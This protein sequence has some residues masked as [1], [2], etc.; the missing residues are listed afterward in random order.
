ATP[1]VGG[2]AS[3]G[4]GAVFAGRPSPEQGA[5]EAI[6]IAR[7]AGIAIDVYGD[8]YDAG[9]ARERIGPREGQPGVAVH[10]AVPRASLWAAMARAVVVLYPAGWDEPFGMAAAEAQA[11]G[12]PVVAVRRGAPGGGISDGLTC[13]L[14]PPG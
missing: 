7:A 1:S 3:A 5:A 4:E 8:P 10:R 12:T 9:Y 11:C 14:V 13:F 6:D 2:S